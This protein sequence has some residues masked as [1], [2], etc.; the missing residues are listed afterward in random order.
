MY[1]FVMMMRVDCFGAQPPA[2]K[3][4][5]AK[6]AGS[7]ESSLASKVLTIVEAFRSQH[8]ILYCMLVE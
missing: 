4:L 5:F 6:I 1:K 8:A 7:C 3:R 2:E